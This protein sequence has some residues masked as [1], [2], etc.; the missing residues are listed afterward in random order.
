MQPKCL[1]TAFLLSPGT[2][3]LWSWKTLA[4]RVVELDRC[5]LCTKSPLWLHSFPP[6]LWV[7]VS[8]TGQIQYPYIDYCAFYVPLDIHQSN[9]TG[10]WR[11]WQ[12][13][14]CCMEL[15]Y[16]IIVSQTNSSLRVYL[17]GQIFCI[18]RHFPLI[19]WKPVKAETGNCTEWRLLQYM[20]SGLVPQNVEVRGPFFRPHVYEL[21]G[22]WINLLCGLGALFSIGLKHNCLL[23]CNCSCWTQIERTVTAAHMP[24]A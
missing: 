6:E 18:Q 20:Q 7:W 24:S 1:V 8:F 19:Y 5:Q 12:Q 22:M 23:R 9:E 13:G 17:L 4:C 10:V 11:R 2:E 3:M 21:L 15:V 16:C 14:K